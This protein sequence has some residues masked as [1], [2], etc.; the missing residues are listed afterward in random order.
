AAYI[1][2]YNQ[3]NVG[4]LVDLFTPDGTLIDSENVAIRGRDDITEEFSE[5][6]E[7]RSNYTL[8]AQVDRIRMITPDVAQ[9]EGVSRLVSPKEATIANHFVVLLA[10][11]GQNWKIAEIRDYP[12]PPDIVAPSE[13]LKE[14]E[15]LVGDWVDE[16]EDTQVTSTVRWGQGNAYLVRD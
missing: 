9:A 15:W 5:A 3:K 16:S 14:L 2:A 13:R 8:H 12:A 1:A 11:Q 7:E 10:R 4:K 6:F